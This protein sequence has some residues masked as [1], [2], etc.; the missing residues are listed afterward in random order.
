VLQKASFTFD[1]LSTAWTVRW[2]FQRAY[3][4]KDQAELLGNLLF[5]E[6][7]AVGILTKRRPSCIE[8]V[9]SKDLTRDVLVASLHCRMVSP[10]ACDDAIFGSGWCINLR[11][12][13]IFERAD[14]EILKQAICLN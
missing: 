4:L 5:G 10:R 12:L 14:D 7:P 13:D 1:G 11:N 8:I 9:C 2:L 6:I 3:Q